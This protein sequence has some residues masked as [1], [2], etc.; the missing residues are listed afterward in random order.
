MA[1]RAVSKIK[2]RYLRESAALLRDVTRELD[3]LFGIHV[4]QVWYAKGSDKIPASHRFVVQ[5]I[6]HDLTHPDTST[7]LVNLKLDETRFNQ[8][9]TK[10]YHEL[11]AE[12]QRKPIRSKQ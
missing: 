2:R 6:D 4:G 7:P 8:Y 1:K 3:S 11:L 9:A 10:F 12:F 5:Q